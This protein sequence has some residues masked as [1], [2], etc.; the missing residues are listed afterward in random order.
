[1]KNIFVFPVFFIVLLAAIACAVHL[2]NNKTIQGYIQPI[3]G[4]SFYIAGHE[5]RL[6]G[7]DAPEYGQKGYNDAILALHAMTFGEEVLC[8]RVEK[9]I[10]DR[11][12]VD[13]FVNGDNIATKLATTC[14]V[15]DYIYNTDCKYSFTEPKKWRKFN[16]RKT[17]LLEI[18]D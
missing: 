5:V 9:D 17:T 4:D 15:W 6:R 12:I 3:D 13:C 18:L 2:V 8:Q 14:V 1:M 11:D 10:Y 16:H 7:I